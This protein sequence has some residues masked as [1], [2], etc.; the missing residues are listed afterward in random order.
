AT[1]VAVVVQRGVVGRQH[2]VFKIFRQS[3]KHLVAGRNLYA[4]YPS[5]QGGAADDLFKYSPTAALG[6]AP[7]AFP[8]YALALLAWSLLGALLLYYGLTRVLDPQPAVLA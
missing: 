7:F 6:F 2:N 8:P 5:E 4:A 1:A 3:F